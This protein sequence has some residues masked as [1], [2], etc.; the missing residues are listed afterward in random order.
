MHIHI[1]HKATWIRKNTR[2]PFTN[3]RATNGQ[4]FVP[5]D[6]GDCEVLSRFALLRPLFCFE[7]FVWLTE[8]MFHRPVQR[9]LRLDSSTGV[10]KFTL[11]GCACSQNELESTIGD[12]IIILYCYCR[13]PSLCNPFF[14]FPFLVAMVTKS[15]VYL[16]WSRSI[17]PL[18]RIA[19]SMRVLHSLVCG[20]LL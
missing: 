8:I 9:G 11:C 6:G 3:L 14:E 20:N 1:T 7:L 12:I 10:M 19:L 4:L 2:L 13:F 15:F 5:K 18:K 17:P 16:W